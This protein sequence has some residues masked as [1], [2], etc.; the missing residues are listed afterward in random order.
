MIAV[1]EGAAATPELTL[2]VEREVI[3]IAVEKPK[4]AIL[5]RFDAQ[6]DRKPS[7][8]EVDRKVQ[9]TATFDQTAVERLALRASTIEARQLP[10]AAASSAS[11]T[12]SCH[13]FGKLG[14]R[15]DAADH[16]AA[17]SPR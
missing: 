8:R 2:A 11:L 3:Q 16:G 14:H 9:L 13:Q 4:I 5:K 15:L 17:P 12:S 7:Q 10:G 6:T 1:P